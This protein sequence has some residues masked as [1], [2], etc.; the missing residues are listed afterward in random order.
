MSANFGTQK[1]VW[2]SVSDKR[3]F[4]CKLWKLIEKKKDDFTSDLF[5]F[6]SHS[7]NKVKFF[8]Q[9][10]DILILVR[11]LFVIEWM[12]NIDRH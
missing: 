3:K 6:I 7:A 8:F 2:I 1:F 10:C 11:F 12:P 5:V 9:S 4:V